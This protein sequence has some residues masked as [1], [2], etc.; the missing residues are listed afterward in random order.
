[1]AEIDVQRRRKSALPVV[2]L[3]LGLVLAVWALWVWLDE[4]GSDRV[5]VAPVAGPVVPAPLADAGTPVPA[6]PAGVVVHSPELGAAVDEFARFAAQPPP[7]GPEHLYTALGIT[8][9]ATALRKVAEAEPGSGAA[10]RAAAGLYAVADRLAASPDS[11]GRQTDRARRAAAT[12][13]EVM[14]RLADTRSPEDR[15]LQARLRELRT[16]S[17]AIDPRR[18]L[19]EETPDVR[20]FFQAAE[21]PLRMLAKLDEPA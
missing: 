10:A 15:E 13:V 1:M 3:V 12:A 9:L 11:A 16:A 17:E 21:A 2:L 7:P 4:D 18:P 6:V 5:R 20:A 19:P 8:R 14:Q